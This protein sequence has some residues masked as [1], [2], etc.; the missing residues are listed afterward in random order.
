MI[1]NVSSYSGISSATELFN[2][3]PIF[4]AVDIF[5]NGCTGEAC[6][7]ATGATVGVP[8]PIVGAGLPGLLAA[9][10]GMIALA[11]RRRNKLA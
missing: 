4:A 10:F 3:N 11:K 8:G 1:F 5:K 7:G 9:C 2:G 6:T